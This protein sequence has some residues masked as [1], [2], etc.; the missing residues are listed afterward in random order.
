MVDSTM[1]IE[2]VFQYVDI[3]FEQ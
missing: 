2:E 1:S 3:Y